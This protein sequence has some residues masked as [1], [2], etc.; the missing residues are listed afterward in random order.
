MLILRFIY[1]GDVSFVTPQ[2]A[3]DILEASNFFKCDRLKAQCEDVLKAGSYLSNSKVQFRRIPLINNS[4]GL[5]NDNAAYLLQAAD[6]FDAR[7]L[8]SCT[9]EY[10]A[11]HYKGACVCVVLLVAH[12]PQRW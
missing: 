12:G 5:E 4:V 2:N 9:F 11:K 10:I 6:R 1:C 8:K 7:Q 3:I